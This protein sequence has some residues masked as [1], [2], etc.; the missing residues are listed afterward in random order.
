MAVGHRKRPECDSP[1]ADSA[2]SEGHAD[3]LAV[4]CF[5]L[6]TF[7]LGSLSVRSRLSLLCRHF[8]SG[9][10]ELTVAS[11]L[12]F[13]SWHFQDVIIN[14]LKKKVNFETVLDTQKN[15]KNSP[16]ISHPP[17]SSFNF[18]VNIWHN[19]AEML[20]INVY[21]EIKVLL[22]TSCIEI[23][24]AF[25]LMYLSIGWCMVP[26]CK[27]VYTHPLISC[28]RTL[29]LFFVFFQWKINFS[30]NM[31]HDFPCLTSSQILLTSPH[32]QLHA[33]FRSFFREWTKG[34]KTIK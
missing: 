29:K 13:L 8:P 26:L 1:E 6:V 11:V 7:P 5:C 14:T 32:F 34:N 3:S 33:F 2:A 12:F 17:H 4:H 15:F 24:L 9:W 19:S 30:C 21:F 28:H 16:I 18:P 10:C 20:K 27:I 22:I 23:L 31:Y 25:P